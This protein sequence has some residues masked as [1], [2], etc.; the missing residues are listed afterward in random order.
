MVRIFVYDSREFPDPDADMTVDQVRASLADF[1][2]EL[3][4]ATVQ[5]TTRGEDTVYQF[6]RQVGTK[7]AVPAPGA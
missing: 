1:L 2:P 6:Q 3:A 5:E 4:S 7:G